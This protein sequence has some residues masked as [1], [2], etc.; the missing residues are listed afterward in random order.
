MTEI[1]VDKDEAF[2]AKETLC[3][4][5]VKPQKDTLVLGDNLD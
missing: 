5:Q 4:L 3:C 2:K 1:D